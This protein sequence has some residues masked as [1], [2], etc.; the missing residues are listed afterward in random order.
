MMQFQEKMRRGQ[1]I[2]K[3][4]AS[5]NPEASITPPRMTCQSSGHSAKN[6]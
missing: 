6:D 3:I 2:E 5:V 1:L 4:S